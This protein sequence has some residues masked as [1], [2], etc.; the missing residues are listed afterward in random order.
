MAFVVSVA[1]GMASFVFRSFQSKP[2]EIGK[3]FDNLTF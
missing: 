2:N 1:W 3:N